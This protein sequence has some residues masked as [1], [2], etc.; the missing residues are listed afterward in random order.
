MPSRDQRQFSRHD[1]RAEIF[2]LKSSQIKQIFQDPSV[3]SSL[4]IAVFVMSESLSNYCLFVC[5]NKAGLMLRGNAACVMI[6]FPA[7]S[8]LLSFQQV[9][10]L[11]M[12]RQRAEA[13]IYTG[14]GAAGC[15]RRLCRRQSRAL[16]AGWPGTIARKGVTTFV[17]WQAI[18]S[19]DASTFGE[20]T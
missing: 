14:S 13:M 18:M 1:T 9:T 16:R 4:M 8:C 7:S 3:K 19:R 10:E 2:R 12:E 17:S 20:E 15:G 6:E 5:F 11:Q